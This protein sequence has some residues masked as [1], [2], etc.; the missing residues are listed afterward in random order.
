MADFSSNVKQKFNLLL[1]QMS[2][3]RWL[4]VNHPQS[5]FTRQDTGKLTFSDTM[6]LIIGM[7]KSTTN[8][9]ISEYF[10]LDPDRVPSQ[11]AFIQRRSQLSPLAFEHLF[12]QF[13]DSFPQTTNTFKGR[14]ILA[15]DGSHIVYST[16]AEI[17]QDYNDPHIINHK[18][19]NHM[20]LNGFVDVSSKA[21]VDAV[22]QPGQ[23][24]DEREAF[25]Q[26][27]DHFQPDDPQKYIVTADRGYE[28]YDLIFHCELKHLNYVFRVKSPSSSK[29]MLSSFIDELPDDK[30]EFDVSVTRFF[31][32][33]KTKIMKE[34]T[35][36]YH[37]MNPSKN[38]PHFKP[39]LNGKHLCVV[40]FRVLKIKTA[41]NT[42]EYIITNLPFS[43]DI[44]DIKTC[45]RLRWGIETSFR[46]LKHV[47][48]LLYLHSKK[49]DFLKQEIYG[50]LILYNFGIFLANEAALEKQ[51]QRLE[52][53]QQHQSQNK[54]HY[55]VDFSSALRIARKYFWRD[56]RTEK[57]IIHLMIK[58]VHAVKEELRQFSR[59]LRGIGAVHF[60]FR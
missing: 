40:Q 58:Y 4:Y 26:M 11:S 33:K 12:S 6:R 37:Y 5:D 21:F 32:D 36:V 46:Y 57:D 2:E 44:N 54:Y 27:L 23:M 51:K 48:G 3:N 18:G 31:T 19:Y 28:S 24:P 7:G 35:Q 41:P 47:N 14:C 17:L 16:N 53:E 10:D 60:A 42:F 15:C 55:Q 1:S 30:D 45:Y 20:H 52:I 13:S 56:S 39:L 22:L 34:Q 9:E 38:T 50:N 29:S 59:P 43:F 49:P 25:H 8:D